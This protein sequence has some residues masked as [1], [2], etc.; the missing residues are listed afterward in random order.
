MKTSKFKLHNKYRIKKYNG[1]YMIEKRYW[2]FSW[3]PINDTC[4]IVHCGDPSIANSGFPRIFET[5]QGAEI[6]V[7]RLIHES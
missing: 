1:K 7:R 5:Y 4:M 6:F 2:L 3:L